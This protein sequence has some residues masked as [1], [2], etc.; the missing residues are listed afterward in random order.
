[1]ALL[2]RAAPRGARRELVLRSGVH[3]M[4]RALELAPSDSGLVIR[5]HPADTAIPWLSGGFAAAVLQWKRVPTGSD[6]L[7]S[8]ATGAPVWQADLSSVPGVHAALHDLHSLRFPASASEPGRRA[9]A[10]RYP[11]ADIELDMFPTGYIK[12]ARSWHAP[13]EYAAAQHVEIA[14]PSRRAISTN[15][16]TYH[17]GIGGPA[18]IFS[19]PVSFWAVRPL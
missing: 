1:M 17:L 14:S 2:R 9:T 4:E 5:S 7:G 11:N 16:A 15:Y 8:G 6:V 12:K 10:A 3:Y 13:R 18:S 19:P